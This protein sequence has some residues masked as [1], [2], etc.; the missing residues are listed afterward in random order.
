MAYNGTAIQYD[1]SGNPVVHGSTRYT[2]EHG[3]QLKSM[4]SG[5][6]TWTYTYNNAGLRTGRYVENGT[7]Y[8]YVY[9]GSQL[10]QMTKDNQV[11]T[12]AYDVAGTPLTMK[13]YT[14]TEE[15]G[16]TVTK[17]NT[18]YY[19]T[20]IQGD[21][22]ALVTVSEEGTE[23]AASYSYTAYGV[24]TATG[25]ATVIALNPLTYRGYV[26]DAETGLYYLQSRYYDPAVGRFINADG[27]VST[28]QGF[29]GN[30]MFA[31]CG[32]NPVNRVD[33]TGMCDEYLW[34]LF[35]VDC[36]SAS[37]PTSECYNP[38]AKQVLVIYDANSSGFLRYFGGEGFQA[39]GEDL[40][41]ELSE[42][43]AVTACPY[44]TMGEFVNAWNSIEGEYYAIYVLGHGYAGGMRCGDE[45]ISNSTQE[46]YKLSD[47]KN[48]NAL[49]I[50]LYICDGATLDSKGNSVANIMASQITG[51]SVWAVANGS[52]NF[53]SSTGHG[54]PVK[55]G[56]WSVTYGR[57]TTIFLNMRGYLDP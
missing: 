20:N 37:C 6:V 40:I 16:T 33:P 49:N 42:K 35:T 50:F 21:V 22:M 19:V 5:D 43:Y 9:N 3:R 48:V 31:Y 55:G 10:V 39:Q 47:L 52:L 28:G 11:V 51:G 36:Q 27:L 12:F 2:W 38:N 24:V 41:A 23:I 15:N 54:Y 17:C 8:K 44:T 1:G 56:C 14:E 30:N 29:T 34:G 25:D 7:S 32:N 13:V 57:I 46:A 45:R 26:Y 18:Y 4:T 53:S